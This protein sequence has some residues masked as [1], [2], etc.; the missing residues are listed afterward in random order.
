MKITIETETD[1]EAIWLVQL[2][3][4]QRYKHDAGPRPESAQDDDS[5]DGL[6]LSTRTKNILRQ[7]NIMTI[8]GLK[9]LSRLDLIK[10]PGFGPRTRVE[11]LNAIVVYQDQITADMDGEKS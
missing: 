10:V 2:L 8:S 4:K 11:I 9:K 1:R 7:Q 6:M 5:I 3:S